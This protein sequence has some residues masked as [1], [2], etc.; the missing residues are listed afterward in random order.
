VTTETPEWWIRAAIVLGLVI[1]FAV[2]AGGIVTLLGVAIGA[3]IR[4]RCPRCGGRI[5]VVSFTTRTRDGRGMIGGWCL[6]CRR[7]LRLRKS[8]G[9]W[10]E[11]P[12]S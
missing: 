11:V 1:A 8:A 5:A 3:A 10:S 7:M 6:G 4:V 12:T 2:A 9:I